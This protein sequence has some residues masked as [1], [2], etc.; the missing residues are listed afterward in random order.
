M[1]DLSTSK[2]NYLTKRKEMKVMQKSLIKYH[3][4]N[5]LKAIKTNRDIARICNKSPAKNNDHEI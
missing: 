5:N 3:E 1:R 4:S 2:E